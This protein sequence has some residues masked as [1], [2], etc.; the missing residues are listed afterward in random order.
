MAEI[1]FSATYGD[2]S[3]SYKVSY[4]A[5]VSMASNPDE[6]YPTVVWAAGK[7]KLKC[8]KKDG[9]LNADPYMMVTSFGRSMSISN[10]ADGLV[11]P[12]GKTKCWKTSHSAE[13]T[14]SKK[15]FVCNAKPFYMK[16]GSL[17]FPSCWADTKFWREKLGVQVGGASKATTRTSDSFEIPHL[18]MFY[19][20]GG[21]TYSSTF[22]NTDRTLY[23]SSPWMYKLTSSAGSYVGCPGTAYGTRSFK[24]KVPVTTNCAGY[25]IVHFY[26]MDG[27]Y[28]STG[29]SVKIQKHISALTSGLVEVSGSAYFKPGPYNVYTEFS[30]DTSTCLFSSTPGTVTASNPGFS[31][32]KGKVF[33]YYPGWPGSP[34][35]SAPSFS[36][37]NTTSQQV[38]TNQTKNV[39]LRIT[40]NDNGVSR[41]WLSKMVYN[42]D[43]YWNDGT[44]IGSYTVNDS[45][46]NNLSAHSTNFST[47]VQ[48]RSSMRQKDEYVYWVVSG[49][50]VDTTGKT[51][52]GT[53]RTSGKVNLFWAYNEPAK[54]SFNSA[55]ISSSSGPNFSNNKAQLYYGG[56]TLNF[57][58]QATINAWGD[59]PGTRTYEFSLN[60]NGSVVKWYGRNTTSDTGTKSHTYSYTIPDNWV[61]SSANFTVYKRLGDTEYLASGDPKNPALG[62]NHASGGTISFYEVIGGVSGMI[63]IK[64]SILMVSIPCSVSGTGYYDKQSS[65]KVRYYV[66][67]FDI[68]ADKV[69]NQYVLGNTSGDITK[70]IAIDLSS[71]DF[72][73]SEAHLYELRLKADVTELLGNV[74]TYTFY[75]TTRQSFMPPQYTLTQTTDE[76]LPPVSDTSLLIRQKATNTYTYKVDYDLALSTSILYIEY[77]LASSPNVKRTKTVNILPT[78]YT[79]G[80]FYGQ[81][82]FPNPKDLDPSDPMYDSEGFALGTKVTA[83]VS[84]TWNLPGSTSV[85][86]NSSGKVQYNVT[87]TRYIYFLTRGIENEQWLNTVHSVTP[88]RADKK[89]KKIFVETDIS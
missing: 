73:V 13:T 43:L 7:L 84:S 31:S 59:R 63:D 47:T 89:S 64:P 65:Q 53:T 32:S 4:S 55:R 35:N 68:D 26:G 5:N 10:Q 56:T 51:R 18:C 2:G 23:I 80:T 50:S 17:L 37:S 20:Y 30:P 11:N 6:G 15:N 36:V 28:Q 85:Y 60:R 70:E 54:V 71:S 49:Y 21:S 1:A 25:L 41:Y 3:P 33:F 27:G 12:I 38:S 77:Y 48:I 52:W 29:H 72:T 45:D 42:V 76:L 9:V 79:G 81:Y 58:L 74:H 19:R 67:V 75:T 16:Q 46:M 86:S 14:V 44:K 82:T 78:G 34:G 83:W 87:P 57:V 24:F 62:T 66:E 69:V 8:T 22:P 88:T 61:G 40:L 39:S